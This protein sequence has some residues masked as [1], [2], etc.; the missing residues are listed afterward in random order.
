[1]VKL[2]VP[3]ANH[4]PAELRLLQDAIT[5][6]NG[7]AKFSGLSYR[8]L[9]DRAVGSPQ[10][11]TRWQEGKSCTMATY[12]RLLQW[13]SDNWPDGE[14]LKWPRNVPRPDPATDEPS[15]KKA[16]PAKQKPGRQPQPRK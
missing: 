4:Q 3:P 6:I 7:Y 2:F 1:M 11:I 9:T 5:V 16:I 12:G 10:L 15:F 14:G 13:F 8:T